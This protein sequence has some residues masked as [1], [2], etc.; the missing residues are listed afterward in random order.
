MFYKLIIQGKFYFLNRTSYDKL[1]AVIQNKNQI[2]YK[3]DI[4]FKELEFL[5]EENFMISIPRYVGNHTDKVW[6][7]TANLFENCAQFAVSGRVMMWKIEEGRLVETKEIEPSGGRTAVLNFN[8]GRD[9]IKEGGKEVEALAELSKSIEN[10]NRN[11]LAYER[12]A[13]VNLKLGNIAEAKEDFQKSINVDNSLAESHIG[14]GRILLRERDLENALKHLNFA[15]KT[16]IALQSIHWQA[17]RA[18]AELHMINEEWEE[19]EFE[20]K[21]LINKVFE[22]SDPNFQRRRQ[23]I[24]NYGIVKYNQYLFDVALELFERAMSMPYGKDKIPEK[25][26]YFFLGMSKKNLGKNGY[27]HDLSKSA[28][29]GNEDAIYM[30]EEIL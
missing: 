9:F 14:L 17:R 19:A 28:E 12:R 21:L 16:S 15:I 6:K 13:V 7:N 29:L 2:Y 3:N 25:D 20:L 18:K 22:K 1:V 27:I 23:D 10:C 8:K 30:L 24:F 5:D 26:K 4:V 11:A